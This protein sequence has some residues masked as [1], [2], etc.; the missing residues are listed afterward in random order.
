ML[1]VKESLKILKDHF[2][3]VT[4]EEFTANLEK[5][6][7][8][9]IAEELAYLNSNRLVDSTS[10]RSINGN[11]SIIEVDTIIDLVSIFLP[12]LLRGSKT[13]FRMSESA[14]IILF[15]KAQAMW[16]QI[17]PKIE[18]KEAALEAVLDAAN[19]PGN[20]DFR[21]VLTVQ[22]RKLLDKDEKLLES[23]SQVW[24]KDS[25]DSIS[26]AKVL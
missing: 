19:N 9:L 2:A 10:H 25:I 21:T 20:A 4:P 3:T 24:L 14:E 16:S 6:C 17:W 13:D 5:F 18:A 22:L 23:V 7:P 12:D 11:D 15:C 8:E 26:A 1:D